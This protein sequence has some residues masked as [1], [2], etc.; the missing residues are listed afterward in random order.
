MFLALWSSTQLK[1][2]TSVLV[3]YYTSNLYLI[4]AVKRYTRLMWKGCAIVCNCVQ[5][6]KGDNKTRFQ[7]R[8]AGLTGYTKFLI[9]LFRRVSRMHVF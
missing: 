4:E 5:I 8:N 7:G 1:H 9:Y 6:G 2:F 3:L